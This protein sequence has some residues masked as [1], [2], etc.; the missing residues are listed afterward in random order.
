VRLGSYLISLTG[1]VIGLAALGGG[2]ISYLAAPCS[3]Y[4]SEYGRRLRAPSARAVAER[5][6]RRPILLLRAFLDDHLAVDDPDSEK[7]FGHF[8]ETAK[9][10]FEEILTKLFSRCGPVIAVGRPGERVPPLG[11]ARLWVSD[12]CWQQAV[13]ELLS[14]A[15]LVIM[16]MGNLENRT[17]LRWEAEQVLQM[18]S[19]SPRKIL[20]VVPPVDERE[21]YDRWEQHRQLSG[22]Q[23]P[24]YEGGEIAARFTIDGSAEVARIAETGVLV[25]RYTRDAPA[26]R[27]AIQVRSYPTL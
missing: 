10:T 3:R 20:L 15:Q 11:A 12:E 16:V 21:V 9:V 25:S 22:G 26:Y 1:K 14:D 23:M 27:T 7:P 18:M 24:I 19:Q 2:A 13:K 8:G 17:G 5:D 4:L 6:E